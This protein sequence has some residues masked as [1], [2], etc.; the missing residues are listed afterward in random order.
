MSTA[1]FR[2]EP[3]V[4]HFLAQV[5]VAFVVLLFLFLPLLAKAQGVAVP[6]PAA[7]IWSSESVQSAIQLL[8]VAV[9]T[10]LGGLITLASRWVLANVRFKNNAKAQASWESMQGVVFDNVLHAQQTAVEA[11]KAAPDATSALAGVKAAVVADVKA[12]LE[13]K[14]LTADVRKVAGVRT[15]EELA[16]LIAKQVE[17]AV[18]KIKAAPAAP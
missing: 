5:A 13:L 8:I 7:S 4:F 14:K 2:R 3:S 1:P 15:D 6:G 12:D 10:A 16:E 18:A 11:A 9:L 17:I